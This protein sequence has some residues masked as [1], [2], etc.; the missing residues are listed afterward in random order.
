M[1]IAFEIINHCNI[2]NRAE[3]TN[4]RLYVIVNHTPY[5]AML[6]KT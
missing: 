3:I 6:I 2:S 1:V 4:H 5:Y